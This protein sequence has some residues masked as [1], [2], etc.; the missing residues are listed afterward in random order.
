MNVPPADV[1]WALGMVADSA[2]ADHV[3]RR[4]ADLPADGA[5][6]MLAAVLDEWTRWQAVKVQ[7]ALAARKLRG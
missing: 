2:S 5:H 6:G 4:L 3:R 7:P 1:S